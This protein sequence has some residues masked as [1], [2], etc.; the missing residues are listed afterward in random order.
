MQSEKDNGRS[1]PDMIDL[2]NPVNAVRKKQKKK[3]FIRMYINT[4]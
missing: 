4:I 3:I 1:V 2:P